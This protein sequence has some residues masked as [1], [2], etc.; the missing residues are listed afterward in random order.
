MLLNGKMSYP[1]I[2]YMNKDLQ[3]IQAVPGYQGAKDF[4]KIIKYFGEDQFTEQ[5]FEDYKK[6]FVSEL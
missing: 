6:A 1:N 5:S 4:E 3:I 2:V